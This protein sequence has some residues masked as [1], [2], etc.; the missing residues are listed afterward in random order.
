M[1]SRE[2][3]T[4]LVQSVSDP[5]AC[6]LGGYHATASEN[7]LHITRQYRSVTCL[8]CQGTMMFRKVKEG[9]VELYGADA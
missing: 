4:H 1:P 8:R 5:T 6:G 9:Q 7:L 3:R 2:P